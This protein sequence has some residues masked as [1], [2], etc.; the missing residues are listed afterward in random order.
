MFTMARLFY[1]KAPSGHILDRLVLGLREVESIPLGGDRH[2]VCWLPLLV[3]A[4]HAA[5]R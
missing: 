4:L 2:S 5:T 1:L 3:Y